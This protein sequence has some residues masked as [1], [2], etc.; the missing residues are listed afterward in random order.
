MKLVYNL[1]RDNPW[2]AWSITILKSKAGNHGHD[3]FDLSYFYQKFIKDFVKSYWKV[4]TFRL[5]EHEVP[6]SYWPFLLI[7]VHKCLFFYWHFNNL[8]YIYSRKYSA[9][10]DKKLLN[11]TMNVILSN[12]HVKRLS[13]FWR[14]VDPWL[15]VMFWLTTKTCFQ[16]MQHFKWPTMI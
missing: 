5:L 6:C 10:A 16:W 12:Y 13:L 15:K 1:K 3:S 4:N 14:S 7:K 9:S 2:V 11:K 8:R